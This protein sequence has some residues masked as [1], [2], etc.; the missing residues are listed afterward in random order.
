MRSGRTAGG[1]S[2]ASSGAGHGLAAVRKVVV[3]M[4]S[5]KDLG[6]SHLDP[7]LA[8]VTLA[9]RRPDPAWTQRVAPGPDGR[10]RH[11][12][13]VWDLTLEARVVQ[14]VL[15]ISFPY[16]IVIKGGSNVPHGQELMGMLAYRLVSGHW[17]VQTG[18]ARMGEEQTVTTAG[19]VGLNV[20][21]GWQQRKLEWVDV[22]WLAMRVHVGRQR[23]GGS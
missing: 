13:A 16:P 5:R 4:P 12:F 3:S 10:Q 19:V 1:R 8:Q 14:G 15:R 6:T 17:R 20:V 2:E 18:V 21:T 22:A 9:A 23:K 7:P 11:L